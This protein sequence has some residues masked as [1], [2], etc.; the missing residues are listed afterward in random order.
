METICLKSVGDL[1]GMDFLIP[2][3]QRGYR[4]KERHVIDLLEDIYNFKP[5]E[6]GEFYCLQ[7]LVIKKKDDLKPTRE[8][9]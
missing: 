6:G 4:W 9:P 3:Y 8:N 1:A 2:D 5:K 7:P